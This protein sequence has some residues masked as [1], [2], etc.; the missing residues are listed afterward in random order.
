MARQQDSGSEAR[1]IVPVSL[2]PSFFLMSSQQPTARAHGRWQFFLSEKEK[3]Q[4]KD[5]SRKAERLFMP[6]K[7]L[8]A[9][10]GK[11]KEKDTTNMLKR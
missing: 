1:C 9:Q 5:Q 3:G 2:S 4:R 10:N 7:Q 6:S 11:Q 8:A